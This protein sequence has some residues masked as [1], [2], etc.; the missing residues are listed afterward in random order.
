M[1]KRHRL[2]DRLG[3]CL[4]PAATQAD[5]HPPEQPLV[6]APRPLE[7][8]VRLQRDLRVRPLIADGGAIWVGEQLLLEVGGGKKPLILWGCVS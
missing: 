6:Q 2:G 4:V 8:L 3:A 1:P 7:V 5:E